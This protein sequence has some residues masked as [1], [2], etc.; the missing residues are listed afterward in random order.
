MTEAASQSRL[1]PQPKFNIK[2]TFFIGLGFMSC[3]LAWGMYNFYF[4]RVLAGQI[5]K[6]G[7]IEQVFRVGYFTGDTRL[8]LANVIMTVDNLLAI[9]LQPYFG[10]LSDRLE[11]RF[12]RRTPFLIIGVPIAAVSLFALPFMPSS[13]AIWLMFLGFVT[14]LMLFNLAMAF[15]RAPVV[16]LMPDLTPSVHRSMANVIINVVGGIGT[17]IGFILPTIMGAIPAVKNSMVGFTS[18]MEQD[19]LLMDIAVFWTTGGIMLVI[20][21]LYLL[22]VKE[23]PTGTKFWHVGDHRIEFDSET[24]QIIPATKAISKIDGAKET[25][26]TR[27]MKRYSMLKELRAIF[28]IKNKSAA[29][30]FLAILFWSA[31]ED[32]FGTNL[33]LWGVEYAG[34][35]DSFLSTL[36]IVMMLLV[37][38][39]G[40]PGA[41]LS[42]RK[43]RLWTMRTGLIMYVAC[44]AGIIVSQEIIR[45][46]YFL[47]G[48]VITIV[49]FGLKALGGGLLAIAAITIIWQ[50][51]PK[52]K[53]GTYTGLYYV[54][55]QTG[56]VVAPLIIGA[57][58]SLF[59]WLIPALG[60]TGAW[61]I[62]NPFCLAMSVIGYVAMVRVNKGEVGDDLS[63]EE[64]KELE[65][66]Y[67]GD[68]D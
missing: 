21:I 10:E 9:F 29:F 50:M 1:Q 18:F 56:S 60:A 17:A 38:V 15:Y 57:L 19:F 58:L 63:D 22:L 6:V 20:L 25:T 54:F 28:K 44:H 42:K 68:S 66:L 61:I 45:A 51:A 2:Q 41:I 49:C 48:F 39:L 40:L 31:A 23:V 4:P 30:A 64:V 35:S 33:S 16:A 3:M 36:F 53:V 62:L 65:R 13:P 8:L 11:S 59:T 24:L 52:D 7:G 5:V 67:G 14:V 43:G 47:P 12:G 55:K 27:K 46:G 34:L 32:G 26:T 37:L